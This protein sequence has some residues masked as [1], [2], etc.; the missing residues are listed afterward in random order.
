MQWFGI[1]ASCV[2]L[3]LGGLLVAEWKASAPGKWLVKP[4]A[5]A[6]FIAAALTAGGPTDGFGWAIVVALVLSFGGD[7]FLI[8]KATV[9]FTLGLVSFL[10]GHLGFAAAFVFRGTAPLW[11]LAAL[12][13]IGV[14]AWVVH[15]WL[16]PHVPGRLRGPVTAYIA[17]IS[18]MVVLAFST[19]G[20]RPD[21]QGGVL[22]TAAVIFFCSDL[23][24][25][26]NRFVSEGFVN[27]L[28]GLPLYY[29]A[30]LLFAWS[31]VSAS[32]K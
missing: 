28:W 22:L 25:A 3:A 2:G 5:S 32:V 31:L 8:P 29:G 6:G 17:V 26:R 13:V 15:R 21:A 12:P 27:R 19:F 14:V 23:A 16:R 4:L 11:G 10:L 7:V 30:Q 24:V 9:W 1:L 18:I 20:H